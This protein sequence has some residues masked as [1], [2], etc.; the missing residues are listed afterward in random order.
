MDTSTGIRLARHVVV[1]VILAAT[2]VVVAWEVLFTTPAMG[3]SRYTPVR[4]SGTPLGGTAVQTEPVDHTRVESVQR[5]TLP[6]G[7]PNAQ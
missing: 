6:S 5:I 2:A 1:T 7:V 3:A 4:V